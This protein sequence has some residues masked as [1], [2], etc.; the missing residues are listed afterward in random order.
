MVVVVVTS[1]G[2]H[3]SPTA[4]STADAVTLDESSHV[5][6]PRPAPI[7]GM[8]AQDAYNAML[9]SEHH[10][11]KLIPGNVTARYGL[12]TQGDTSPPADRMPVWAYTVESGCVVTTSASAGRCVQWVFA[13]ASDGK[14]LGV[15]DQQPTS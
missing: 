2:S 12:L 1:C 8:T 4:S 3:D 13:R 14:N 6:Y 5:F 11:P 15:V 10:P 9:H 7:D